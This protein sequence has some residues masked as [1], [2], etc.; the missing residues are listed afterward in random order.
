M[1]KSL[2][3]LSAIILLFSC[4]VPALAVGTSAASAVLIEAESG[5]IVYEKDAHAR[6]GPASTTKIMTA[7]VAIENSTLDKVVTVAPEA[8]NVEGSSA[9]LYAGE[10]VT[11]ETLL[12]ALML[13]SANDAAAAI[14][15][16]V[17]GGMEE[18]AALMNEKAALLGLRDTHFENPHGLDAEDHYTSA[19]DLAMIARAALEN[20]TFRKIVSTKN[21]A[22]KMNGGDATRV[23]HNHN[24]LLHSYDDIIGVKT[25]FTKKCGRTLVSAAERDG[26][27]VIAVTLDDG[28]DWRDHRA[29]LDEGLSLYERVT[30]CRTGDFE[31]EIDTVGGKVRLAAPS[32]VSVTLPRERGEIEI[33]E[34]YF[35]AGGRVRFY[36]DGKMIADVALVADG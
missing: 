13:G 30:L 5:D 20:E 32:D 23:F 31:T 29:L 11:M 16:E 25:G 28:D 19:Y 27:T 35:A 6:R 7:L 9:Y 3:A 18:F 21:Y 34:E 36:L 17:A 2:A 14:A 1:K 15:Y 22:A 26:V 8:A 10:Q 12:Y 33:A 4:S 24:R